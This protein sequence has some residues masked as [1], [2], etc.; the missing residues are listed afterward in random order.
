MKDLACERCGRAFRCGAEE[1]ACWCE[2]FPALEPLPG[3]GC[4]CPECLQLA[5]KER[6]APGP[7]P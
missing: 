4:L 2:E 3:L 1:G 7:R 6:S 5:L